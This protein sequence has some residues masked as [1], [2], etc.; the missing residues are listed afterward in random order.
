MAPLEPFCTVLA[1]SLRAGGRGTPER[2]NQPQVAVSL[3]PTKATAGKLG[4]LTDS[5]LDAGEAPILRHHVGIVALVGQHLCHLP[6]L[7]PLPYPGLQEDPKAYVAAL[8]GEL[9][10]AAEKPSE[11]LLCGLQGPSRDAQPQ[12]LPEH[13]AWEQDLIL[14]LVGGASAH[15]HCVLIVR[16]LLPAQV[17]VL[18]HVAAIVD[19]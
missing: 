16:L 5:R 15:H 10:P 17:V 3:P 6:G 13:T 2:P 14:Y 8:G 4:A 18:G 12:S 1:L 9:P 7:L 19:L 11:D